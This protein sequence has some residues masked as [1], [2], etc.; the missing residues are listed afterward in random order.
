MN[1]KS[2]EN[3]YKID[4]RPLKNKVTLKAKRNQKAYTL[5]NGQKAIYFEEQ[6]SN[7]LVFENDNWQYII[8]VDKRVSKVTPETLVEIANTIE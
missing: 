8:R 4:I 7:V 1:E 5:K 3:N 6:V 2:Q